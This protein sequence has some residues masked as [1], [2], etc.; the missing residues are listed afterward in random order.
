MAKVYEIRASLALDSL[1]RS[2]HHFQGVRVSA[3]WGHMLCITNEQ[4][5]YSSSSVDCVKGHYESSG[6]GSSNVMSIFS[7]SPKDRG[8]IIGS[9]YLS[10]YTEQFGADVA[11]GLRGYSRIWRLTTH[12]DEQIFM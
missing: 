1:N 3:N 10:D 12:Y 9:L 2:T 4:G 11:A 7:L 6:E 8:L 5:G